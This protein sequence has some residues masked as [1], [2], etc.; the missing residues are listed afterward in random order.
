MK[1]NPNFPFPHILDHKIEAVY[2][3]ATY[4]TS[5]RIPLYMHQYYPGWSWQLMN[6]EYFDKIPERLEN[7]TRP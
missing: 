1:E 3:L 7:D 6:Q 4:A 2:I 5:A